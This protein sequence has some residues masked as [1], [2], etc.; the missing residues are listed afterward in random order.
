[1]KNKA[2]S[3]LR[4]IAKQYDALLCDVWG[5]LA[6]GRRAHQRAVEALR[7]F[8]ASSGPVILLSN[9]P[10]P[11]ESLKLQLS[12]FGVPFDCFDAAVTSGDLAREYLAGL[13][14]DRKISLF[15]IGPPRDM[16]VFEG[17]TVDLVGVEK[18]DLVLCTGLYDDTRE[19]PSDYK[20]IL[21]VIRSK[22]LEMLCANPDIE[23]MRG[24]VRVYCAGAIARCYSEL[25]GRVRYV[26]KPF[27]AIYKA[28][29][30]VANEFAISK[31]LNPLV[32]GDNLMTDISGA[33]G[34]GYKALFVSGGVH[35]N[36]KSEGGLQMSGQLFADL[37][38]IPDMTIR[39]LLW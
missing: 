14:A 7:L 31:V 4:E 9:A 39:S 27:A 28:A 2:I 21:T 19:S 17:L 13:S 35:H 18:A 33:S 30:D 37:G 24:D 26:G 38:V 36:E 20:E 11:S 6:D 15:H 12:E 16:P 10:R 3:G 34:V 23:T 8:R 22:N 1:M 5:V 29:I 32:V 25:N